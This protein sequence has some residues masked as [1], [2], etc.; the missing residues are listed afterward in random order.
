MTPALRD[1]E[2]I[3]RGK[4]A[5][6]GI[7]EAS[8]G[9][10]LTVIDRNKRFGIVTA[11]KSWEEV[12]TKA[13]SSYLG[14]ES[15]FAGVESTGLKA[16]ELHDAPAEEVKTRMLQATKR[17]LKRGNVGAICLGCAGMAGMNETVK[18]A[19]IEELGEQEGKAVVIV[20]GVQAGISF[21]EGALR[22][23]G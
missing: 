7:F 16:V 6:T 14:S 19:C 17:L 3:Q 2:V 12:L 9:F 10:S 8:I 5:V 21:I 20:D 15:R 18:E 22:A 23:G 1:E 11:G 13:V 4:K